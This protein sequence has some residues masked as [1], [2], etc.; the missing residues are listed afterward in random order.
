MG[1]TGDSVRCTWRVFGMNGIDSASSGNNFLVTLVRTSVGI[2][3]ISSLVPDKFSLGNNYPNPFNPETTIKF[4]IANS[5]FAELK[6]YDS[7]GSEVSTLVNEDLKPGNYEYK[8]YAGNLPS[9]AYFYR[10]KTSEFTETKRMI[11]VK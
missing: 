5:T 4:D 11:L 10:L 9:G 1:T 3:V 7:R 6:I 8:F 2:N